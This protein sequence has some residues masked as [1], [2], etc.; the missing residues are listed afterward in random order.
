MRGDPFWMTAKYKGTC[1]AVGCS[2][3]IRRG[4]RIFYYPNAKKAYVGACAS[5]ADRDFASTSFD[6]YI[7][8][9]MHV[10]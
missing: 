1:G 2:D 6:E 7:N 10:R 8:E 5:N 9:S 4:D 3:P